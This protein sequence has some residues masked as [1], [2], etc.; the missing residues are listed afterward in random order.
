VEEREERKINNDR[1][2]NE[3]WKKGRK[4]ERREGRKEGEGSIKIKKWNERR[5]RR[6]IYVP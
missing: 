3:S 1:K 4:G 2:T 6:L 5:K